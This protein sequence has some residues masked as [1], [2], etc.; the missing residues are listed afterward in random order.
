MESIF[1]RINIVLSSLTFSII[2]TRASS[3]FMR[4]SLYLL[5]VFASLFTGSFLRIF[6]GLIGSG[7]RPSSSSSFYRITNSS[8]VI[9]FL[10]ACLGFLLFC[11]FLYNRKSFPVSITEKKPSNSYFN[12]AH[13]VR[14]AV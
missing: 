4:F 14:S 10:V 1:S 13:L 2:F 11:L 9:V 6:D 5:S 12:R 8:Q 7:P 3:V